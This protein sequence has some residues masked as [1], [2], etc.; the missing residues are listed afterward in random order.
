MSNE[1]APNKP[2]TTPEN[3]G[4]NPS[5]ATDPSLLDG[6]K[7]PSAEPPADAQ[8]ADTFT[9]YTAETLKEALGENKLP[10]GV[11]T[12]FMD[13]ANEGHFSKETISSLAGLNKSL[14]ESAS[15]EVAKSWDE[16]QTQWK[17]ETKADPQ[18]GGEKLDKTLATAVETLDKYGSKELRAAVDFTGLA[19]NVHFIRFLHSVSKALP[20]EGR[21][22]PS[23]PTAPAKD[24][25]NRLFSQTQ[26]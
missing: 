26:E 2:E 25:A 20:T 11:L 1:P 10:E 4:T 3:T 17:N 23:I 12:K 15:Q 24:L 13:V 9:P 6:A 7:P 21:P 22:H 16:L 19:N 8:P 5:G 18:I 14:V